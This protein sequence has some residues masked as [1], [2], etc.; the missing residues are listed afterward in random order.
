MKKIPL[1]LCHNSNKYQM[2]MSSDDRLRIFNLISPN[3]DYG[4]SKINFNFDGKL[5][6]NDNMILSQELY[7]RHL[8]DIYSK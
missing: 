7:M 1:N 6:L 3:F 5:P 2:R 8:D 4:Y